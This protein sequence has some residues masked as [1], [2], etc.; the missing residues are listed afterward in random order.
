MMLG[1]D[2]SSDGLNVERVFR[3]T[4]GRPRG[5]DAGYIHEMVRFLKR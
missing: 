5:L 1:F 2:S 4:S 3:Y